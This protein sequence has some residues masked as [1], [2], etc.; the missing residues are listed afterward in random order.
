M[1]SRLKTNAH[2]C[3]SILYF[4][5]LLVSNAHID[6]KSKNKQAI[7]LPCPGIL[8]VSMF[9]LVKLYNPKI[10]KGILLWGMM[11]ITVIVATDCSWVYGASAVLLHVYGGHLQAG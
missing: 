1:Y 3:T 10:V 8:G 5:L 6:G 4:K 2:D 7:I 11:L 9:S